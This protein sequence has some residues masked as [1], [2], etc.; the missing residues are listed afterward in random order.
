MD[1]RRVFVVNIDTGLTVDGRRQTAASGEISEEIKLPY[2]T[3]LVEWSAPSNFIVNFNGYHYFVTI[4]E[5]Q[6]KKLKEKV[7]DPR[8]PLTRLFR[9]RNRRATRN[10][11]KTSRRRSSRRA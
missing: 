1:Q 9:S 6:K 4:N 2:L 8:P 10:R 7:P 3:E 5:E 11:R